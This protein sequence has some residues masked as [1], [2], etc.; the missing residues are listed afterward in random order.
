MRL[1]PGAVVGGYRLTGVLG[2]GGYG[3][4]YLAKHPRLERSVALKVL[5]PGYA[6]DP[7][8]RIAFDR[9]ATLVAGLDHPNIVSVYDRNDP[10]DEHLWLSMR[11]VIGGDLNVSINAEPQ[12]LDLP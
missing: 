11:P 12:G 5:Y 10:D 3:A 8:V 4:V 6:A 7:K 1:Q 2:A 9:E